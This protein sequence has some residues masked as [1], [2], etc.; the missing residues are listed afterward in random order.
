M[1][2][3]QFTA[4]RDGQAERTMTYCIVLLPDCDILKCHEISSTHAPAF[5]ALKIYFS[6]RLQ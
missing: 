2:F 6:I 3:F 1:A 4:E 5:S